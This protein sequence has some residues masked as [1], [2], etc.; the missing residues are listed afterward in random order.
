MT[1]GT[2]GW[3]VRSYPLG[4]GVTD[5]EGRRISPVLRSEGAALD[6]FER[7]IAAAKPRKRACLCCGA[8]FES[9]GVH[10]RLCAA[11]GRAG[12]SLGGGAG[13]AVPDRRR[14]VR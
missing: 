9:A 8:A 14:A 6:W 10:D 1:V 11:C 2:K 12:A 4:Y 3:R 7:R 5:G 13:H